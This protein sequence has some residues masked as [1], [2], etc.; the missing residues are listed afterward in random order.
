M[1]GYGLTMIEIGFQA[2]GVK[3][4]LCVSKSKEVAESGKAERVSAFIVNE[5]NT[6]QDAHVN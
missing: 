1:T 2:R 6:F 3:L 5:Q 4:T